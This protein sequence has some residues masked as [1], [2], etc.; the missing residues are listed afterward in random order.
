[1]ILGTNGR[2]ACDSR[3]R[4]SAHPDPTP[5]KEVYFPFFS[6]PP[7]YPPNSRIYIGLLRGHRLLAS[8]RLSG[9]AEREGERVS[10]LPPEG[11][12]GR[13][14]ECNPWIPSEVGVLNVAPPVLLPPQAFLRVLAPLID[15]GVEHLHPASKQGS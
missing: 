12:L 15:G 5:A 6:T 4:K 14:A 13:W 9:I 8:P 7:P 2:P 11:L 1:M 3:K 10:R